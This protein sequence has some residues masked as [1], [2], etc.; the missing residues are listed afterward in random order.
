MTQ[1]TLP[2]VDTTAIRPRTQ[3][4]IVET[5]E[6]GAGVDPETAKRVAELIVTTVDASLAVDGFA[7]GNEH[8]LIIG[9]RE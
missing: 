9:E 3:L 2:R 6:Q 4:Q 5:L 8:P 1:N 7:K